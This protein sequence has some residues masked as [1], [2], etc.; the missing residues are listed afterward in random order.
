MIGKLINDYIMTGKG[1]ALKEN[2]RGVGDIAMFPLAMQI[3]IIARGIFLG[4][5]EYLWTDAIRDS[6]FTLVFFIIW[7]SQIKHPIRMSRMYYLCPMNAD[8]R[9]AYIKNA[10]LF[11][12]ILH[13]ILTVIVCAVLYL[14]FEVSIYSLL[15]ILICGLMYSFL[16]NVRDN[17]KDFMRAVFL[18]PAMYISSYIQFAI[19]AKDLG[20][21]D[22]IFAGCSFAFLLIVEL[23]MFIS[24]MRAVNDDIK[25]VAEGEDYCRC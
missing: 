5:V 3:V 19:P 24:V 8:E 20:A 15:Y 14:F 21:Q 10:Y 9:S 12:S 4:G 16:S 2:A 13:S 7:I 25:I 6:I 1:T 22:Y 11:R 17:K 23:P 18:K